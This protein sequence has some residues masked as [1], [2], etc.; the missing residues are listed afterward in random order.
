M[1]RILFIFLFSINTFICFGQQEQL[2]THYDMNSLSINPAYAGSNAKTSISLLSRRQW[3]SL[4]GAPE[5]NTFTFSHAVNQD[6]AVG[7]NIKQGTIGSFKNTSPLNEINVAANLAYHKTISKN[8]RLAVGLKL[9]YFNYNFDISKLDL[10]QQIDPIFSNKS[11]NINAPSTG[12]GSYLYS[13]KN[14]IGFSCPQMIFIKKD[15]V[16]FQNVNHYQLTAG[17]IFDV[18]DKNKIKLTTQFRFNSFSPVQVDVNAHYIIDKMGSIGAFVRSEG[19]VGLMLMAELNKNFKLF[20]SWDSKIRPLNEYVRYS[21]EVGLQYNVPFN[22]LPNRI[23][24]PR[25]F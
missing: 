9:G 3:T 24:I 16:N 6:F 20:Y 10:Y 14:F 17:Q 23:I 8:Y 1:K 13:K 25:F 11:Y 7:L 15:E 2:Y 5:Y 4:S 12:F 18:T 21:H 22:L 19:D